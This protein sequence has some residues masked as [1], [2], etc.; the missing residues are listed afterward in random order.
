MAI[1]YVL[2]MHFR[3]PVPFR[4]SYSA[5]RSQGRLQTHPAYQISTQSGNARLSYG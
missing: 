4:Q 3:P 1:N 2:S 5:L